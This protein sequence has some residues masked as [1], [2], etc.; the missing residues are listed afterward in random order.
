MYQS[1]PDV[2]EKTNDTERL[3]MPQIKIRNS[4]GLFYRFV[5]RKLINQPDTCSIKTEQVHL[6]L[7]QQITGCQLFIF[8]AF[9]WFHDN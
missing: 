9:S 7:V 2:H 4:D 8:L 6:G 5:R 1:P 3:I